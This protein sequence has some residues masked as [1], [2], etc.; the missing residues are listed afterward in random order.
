MNIIV[1]LRFAKSRSL[2]CK[3]SSRS[4]TANFDRKIYLHCGQTLFRKFSG[5]QYGAFFRNH[6]NQHRLHFGRQHVQEFGFQSPPKGVSLL[7]NCTELR[8]EAVNMLRNNTE[9]DTPWGSKCSDFRHQPHFLRGAVCS[10]F[11]QQPLLVGVS[12]LRYSSQHSPPKG[13][14]CSNFRHQPL[15]EGSAC[16]DFRHQP[17]LEGVSMLRFSAISAFTTKRGQ[18]SP[19]FSPNFAISRG[20]AS[21]GM[22]VLLW[23]TCI[24]HD[25]ERS[26]LGGQLSPIYPV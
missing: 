15:L 18:H 16:S 5:W 26:V 9:N 17:L 22:A 19:I 3:N 2:L 8:F 23:I 11:Q 21:A 1:G 12:M 6:L 10:D 7:R 20:S 13:S 25:P 14:A 4:L 24:N